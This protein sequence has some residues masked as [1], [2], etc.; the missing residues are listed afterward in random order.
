MRRVGSHRR[1]NPRDIPR[2]IEECVEGSQTVSSARDVTAF[3][4][5]GPAARRLSLHATDHG[6]GTRAPGRTRDTRCRLHNRTHPSA[7]CSTWPRDRWRGVRNTRADRLALRATWRWR[8]NHVLNAPGDA[9]L[10]DFHLGHRGGACVHRRGVV[11]N[12]PSIA[13]RG[14]PRQLRTRRRSDGVDG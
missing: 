10:S 5:S 4:P 3:R 13:A 1:K 9:A 6:R 8:R 2:P 14:A 12:P 7:A 11:Y